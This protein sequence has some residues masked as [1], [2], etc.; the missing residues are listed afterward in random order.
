MTKAEE[1][2][3]NL[4]T[5]K[6]MSMEDFSH[7]IS[8]WAQTWEEEVFFETTVKTLSNL[9]GGDMKTS[10]IFQ[11]FLFVSRSEENKSDAALVKP[12]Q[13]FFLMLFE[14]S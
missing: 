12:I 5:R 3:A 6:G 1:F 4:H 14:L 10:L 7:F 13:V 2:V 11:L 9:L 8:P